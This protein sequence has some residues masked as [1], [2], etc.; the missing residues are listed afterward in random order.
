VTCT[1]RCNGFLG[2][3][4]GARSGTFDFDKIR[5]KI[6]FHAFEMIDRSINF[7]ENEKYI[8]RTYG[9]DNL[10]NKNVHQK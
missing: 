1:T 4:G 9:F 6:D 10:A 5:R 7:I 2:H 3:A 8:V